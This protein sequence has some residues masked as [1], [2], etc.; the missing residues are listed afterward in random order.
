MSLA[1][2][3]VNKQLHALFGL[4]ETYCIRH[5]SP[6]SLVGDAAESVICV[7]VFNRN[8]EQKQIRPLPM[9]VPL[10]ARLPVGALSTGVIA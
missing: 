3:L 1:K 8:A 6:R 2:D 9:L 10:G 5:I 4:R 7:F